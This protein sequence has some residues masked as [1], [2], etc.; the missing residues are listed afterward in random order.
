MAQEQ[1]EKIRSDII[2]GLLFIESILL[3]LV[4]GNKLYFWLLYLLS[5]V[6]VF[7]YCLIVLDVPVKG[8]LKNTKR[9]DVVFIVSL[10]AIFNANAAIFNNRLVLALVFIG[11]YSG[12]RFLV[13]TFKANTATQIQR[14]G[15]NLAVLFIVFLGSNLIA[16]LEIIAEKTFGEFA[17]LPFNILIFALVQMATYYNFMKNRVAK[18]VARVYSVALALLLT[19]TSLI[20]GFYIEKYP[21]LYKA[22]NSA[23]LSIV[24]LPLFLITIY[25]LTY[26]LMIHKI[27][28]KFTAKVII[29]YLSVSSVIFF[30]LFITIKWFGS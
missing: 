27:Q 8:F 4:V 21:N 25:Y 5:F 19:E 3:T 20:A 13:K 18:R 6:S 10:A 24:T 1:L 26:G 16:N 15:F 12:L 14:N 23:N 30:T 17:I 29:E 2:L 28:K 7:L 9:N 22:E 11:F